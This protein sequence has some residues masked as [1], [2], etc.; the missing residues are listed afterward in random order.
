MT[1]YI[2]PRFQTVVKRDHLKVFRHVNT[3]HGHDLFTFVYNCDESRVHSDVL[4][5]E[6]CVDLKL[7]LP[8]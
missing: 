7:V 2:H 5:E 3:W 6:G 4:S 8:I 1:V